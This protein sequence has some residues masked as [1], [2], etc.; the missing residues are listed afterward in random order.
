MHPLLLNPHS[1]L[2]RCITSILHISFTVKPEVIW[3]CVSAQSLLISVSKHGT[4]SSFFQSQGC[5]IFLFLCLTLDVLFP[6]LLGDQ[7]QAPH[8]I[9]QSS[10]LHFQSSLLHCLILFYLQ[11]PIALSFKNWKTKNN[12]L[13]EKKKSDFKLLG[14]CFCLQTSTWNCFPLIN[15]SLDVYFNPVYRN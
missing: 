10:R 15:D 7:P 8:F 6:F 12:S 4:W 5:G 1:L 9:F 3:W 13:S 11:I 14:W 2:A